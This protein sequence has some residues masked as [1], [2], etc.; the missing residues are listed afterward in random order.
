MD[1]NG[2]RVW[3]ERCGGGGGGVTAA[4][5]LVMQ[6]GDFSYKPHPVGYKCIQL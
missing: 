4:R 2:G 6:T 5:A 3:L 1:K